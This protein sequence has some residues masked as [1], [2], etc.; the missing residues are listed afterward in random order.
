MQNCSN[1]DPAPVSTATS[2]K[3]QRQQVNTPC[4]HQMRE[5]A[6]WF[7]NSTKRVNPGVVHGIPYQ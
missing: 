2:H 1:S 4:T 3:R 5:A 6:Y 7:A